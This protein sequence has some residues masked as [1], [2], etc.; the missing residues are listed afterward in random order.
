[1]ENWIKEFSDNL[2]ENARLVIRLLS[3]TMGYFA[4]VLSSDKSIQSQTIDPEYIGIMM[5]VSTFLFSFFFTQTKAGPKQTITFKVTHMISW[6]VFFITI[7]F[8]LM[9]VL[10]DVAGNLP[11]FL[12]ATLSVIINLELYFTY[13]YFE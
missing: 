4:V 1:M 3:V 10:S 2:I 6:L 8:L 13:Y 12:Y 11:V 5:M 9:S 7:F